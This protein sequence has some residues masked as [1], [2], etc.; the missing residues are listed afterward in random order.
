MK[1]SIKFRIPKRRIDMYRKLYAALLAAPL[2]T[3][4]VVVPPQYDHEYGYA[5]APA[6]PVIVELGVE[7]YYYHSGYYYYYNNNSWSYSNAKTGPWRELPKDR[8]PR[9]VRSKGH[10]HG[11]DHNRGQDDDDHYRN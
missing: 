4:C 11:N 5:V 9:E 10:G 2:L 6:L 1:I 7:P 8:Y 3:A